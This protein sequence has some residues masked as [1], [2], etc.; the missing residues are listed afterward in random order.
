MRNVWVLGIVLCAAA[1]TQESEVTGST[2]S[3]AAHLYTPYN[4][5]Q[6]SQCVDVC[7]KCNRGNTTTCTTACTLRGAV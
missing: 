2:N 6:M 3:C 7:I 5:K 1:C 4:P